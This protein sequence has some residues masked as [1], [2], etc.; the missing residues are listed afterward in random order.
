MEAPARPISGS[1]YSPF[2]VGPERALDYILA[3]LKRHALVVTSVGTAVVALEYEQRVVQHP[4]LL[5][6]SDDAVAATVGIVKSA[7]GEGFAA[8]EIAVLTR[9]NS[10]LAPAELREEAE[11]AG[12]VH[13]ATADLTLPLPGTI[14]ILS[15]SSSELDVYRGRP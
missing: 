15:T 7:L 6:S 9:V 13:V 11:R 8:N 10:L 4:A 12:F 3:D 5:E 14:R 2:D 1:E